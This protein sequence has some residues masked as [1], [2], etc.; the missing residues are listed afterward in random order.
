MVISLI[1]GD[2][3]TLNV[4]NFRPPKGER[5]HAAEAEHERNKEIKTVIFPSM[6]PSVLQRLIVDRRFLLKCITLE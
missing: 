2:L 1:S 6:F 4:Q 5:S 3:D